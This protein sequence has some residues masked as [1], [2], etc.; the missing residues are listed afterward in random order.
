[1]NMRCIFLLFLAVMLG[2]VLPAQAQL[3]QINVGGVIN[4]G[5]GIYSGVSKGTPFTFTE[6]FNV[7]NATLLSSTGSTA[8]YTDPTGTSSFSFD[9]FNFSGNTPQIEVYSNYISGYPST[10]PP[11]YGFDFSQTLASGGGFAVEVLSGD[12]FV[13]PSTSLNSVQMF[14]MSDFP[15]IPAAVNQGGNNYASGTISSFSVQVEP[16]PEPSSVALFALAIPLLWWFQS[17]R[18]RKRVV[19]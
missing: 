7:A 19:A 8:T 17:R 12:P 18:H 14:P 6:N 16:T 9:G 5:S 4:Y 15:L 2:N 11:I 1:M 3:L 10:Y 13:A